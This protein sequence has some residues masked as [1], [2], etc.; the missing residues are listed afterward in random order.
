MLKVKKELRTQQCFLEIS[1]NCDSPLVGMTTGQVEQ[2]ST[3]DRTREVYLNL[4]TSVILNPHP[5]LSGFGSPMCFTQYML[6]N[7]NS[8]IRN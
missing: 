2:K 3:H 8:A 5:N 4:P 6:L 7:N 1:E